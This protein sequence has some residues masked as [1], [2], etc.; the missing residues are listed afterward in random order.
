MVFLH[1]SVL[2]SAQIGVDAFQVEVE[3]DITGGLPGLK[4]VGLAEGAVREALDRVKAAIKNS[5]LERPN[6]HVTINPRAC[7]PS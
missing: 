1:A 2:S 5:A 3:I 4:M 7:G 6:R